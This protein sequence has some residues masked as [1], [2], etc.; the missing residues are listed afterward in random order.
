LISLSPHPV[1]PLFTEIWPLEL[2]FFLR[3][4]LNRLCASIACH[5][6]LFKA[7][8]SFVSGEIAAN[9]TAASFFGFS[10]CRCGVYDYAETCSRSTAA[11]KDASK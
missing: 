1:Q 5:A 10:F 3:A 9:W 2:E 11:V 6:K 4:R 7:Y 8:L